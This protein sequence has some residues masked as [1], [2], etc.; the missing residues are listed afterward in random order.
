M[1]APENLTTQ[2]PGEAPAAPAAD[3]APDTKPNEPAV[4]SAKHNG[5]GI[6]IAIDADGKRVGDFSGTKEEAQAEAERLNDGGEPFLVDEPEPAAVVAK[7]PL[8]AAS[9]VNA[10]ELQQPVMTDE[11]WLC[12]EPKEGA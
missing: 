6:W 10:S 8:K 9:S 7:G 5:R 3:T 11:G 2:T 4:F 1:P 12:P